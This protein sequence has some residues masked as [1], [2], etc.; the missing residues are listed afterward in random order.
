MRWKIPRDFVL[1]FS[2]MVFIGVSLFLTWQGNHWAMMF[3]LRGLIYMICGVLFSGLVVGWPLTKLHRA[4]SMSL[5]GKDNGQPS[6]SSIKTIRFTGTL[7]M[8][9]Q[10]L[11]VYYCAIYAYHSWVIG[12]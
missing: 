9:G 1:N 12:L 3:S 2:A 7:L 8:L 6:E 5:I 10:L 11:T 4:F